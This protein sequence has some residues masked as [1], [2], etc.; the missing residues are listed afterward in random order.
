[1]LPSTLPARYG[2][3]VKETA[4]E[5]LIQPVPK[6]N[7][8]LRGY[9]LLGLITPLALIVAFAFSS[10]R[11]GIVIF[12]AFSPAV[13]YLLRSGPGDAPDFPAVLL[14][15]ATRLFNRGS[16]QYAFT[17]DAHFAY[18]TEKESKLFGGGL[19]MI[20][21][22]RELILLELNSTSANFLKDDL[23]LLTDYCNNWLKREFT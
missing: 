11:I 16:E 1:M 13:F 6:T 15:K 22:E 19:V 20:E 14:N 17:E 9:F 7:G 21:G 3:N 5:L 4:T 10:P 18:F 12:G 23:I 8:Q 2:F